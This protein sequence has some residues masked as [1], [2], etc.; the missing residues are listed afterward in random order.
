MGKVYWLSRHALSPAQVSAVKLLHGDSVEIV[1]EAVSFTGLDG[2]KQA[3][4]E[5]TDGYVYAV[6][7]AHMSI[8]AALQGCA[9]GLFE[10]HPAKRL[11][12]SFGL[13]SVYHVNDG[14]IQQ[15]YQNPDP[16]SDLGE[17]LI[18]VIR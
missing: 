2:L 11:D 17:A 7:P 6:V 10:N 12:G 13:A 8:A 16:E 1:C 5:R 18:P 9:F 14:Q 15:V 4:S 3:I